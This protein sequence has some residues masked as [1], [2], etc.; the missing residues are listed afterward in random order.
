[1]RAIKKLAMRGKFRINVISEYSKGPKKMTHN[2]IDTYVCQA[3][4]PNNGHIAFLNMTAKQI[5]Q[6]RFIMTSQFFTT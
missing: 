3:I 2:G 5:N 6:T 4:T 1:M